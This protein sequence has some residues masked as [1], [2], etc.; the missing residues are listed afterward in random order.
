[1][2][3]SGLFGLC[4]AGWIA[5]SATPLEAQ[6][7]ENASAQPAPQGAPQ[8]AT[9]MV[10][11]PAFMCP[12]CQGDVRCPTCC[13]PIHG[14]GMRA[15]CHRYAS[16]IASFGY[17]NCN[18]R[19]SYKFPVFPQYTYHWPGMYS[20]QTMTE[21]VGPYRYPGLKHPPWLP[22]TREDSSKDAGTFELMPIPEPASETATP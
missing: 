8:V 3:N 14:A 11:E 12:T 4:L 10:A 16:Y 20:Q 13:G 5:W 15:C 2:R 19:G 18:C 17:F 9:G 22:D 21:H 7:L 6:Q 1:M